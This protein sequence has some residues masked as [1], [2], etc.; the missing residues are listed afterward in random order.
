MILKFSRSQ[1]GSRAPILP[2]EGLNV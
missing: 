2:K 1:L